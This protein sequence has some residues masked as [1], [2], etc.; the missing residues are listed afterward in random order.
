MRVAIER[1]QEAHGLEEAQAA[2]FELHFLS[3]P[4]IYFEGIH[5]VSKENASDLVL[6][7]V[8]LDPSLP[9][10]AVLSAEAFL[11]KAREIAASRLT[12]ASPDP[13]S[14]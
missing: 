6:P 8:S 14:S 3:I 2:E 4:G 9:T 5:L 1:I 7:V 13:L 10:T 12:V 11:S